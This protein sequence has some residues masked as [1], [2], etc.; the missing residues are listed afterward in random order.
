MPLTAEQALRN[1]L[2]Q[3]RAQLNLVESREQQS[4]RHFEQR[5]QGVLSLTGE[6]DLEMVSTLRQREEALQWASH[7][8]QSV[9]SERQKTE[10]AMQR[11]MAEETHAMKV[12]GVV[13]TGVQERAQ[14]MGEE[15][16]HL[17]GLYRHECS[18]FAHLQHQTVQQREHHW[19]DVE[20]AKNEFGHAENVFGEMQFARCA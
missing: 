12:V 2:A 9:A 15:M 16:T 18:A 14:R 20:L 6:R 11:M 3:A 17:L 4:A 8:Q 1:E 5:I 19:Q 13:Q 7:E 10:N